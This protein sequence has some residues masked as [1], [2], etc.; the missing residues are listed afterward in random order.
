[1]NAFWAPFIVIVWEVNRGNGKVDAT[2]VTSESRCSGCI[3]TEVLTNFKQNFWIPTD[4]P[5]IKIKSNK[6]VGN[7]H[8]S[9]S[10][11]LE[12]DFRFWNSDAN[13]N[14]EWLLWQSR[15]LAISPFW[16]NSSFIVASCQWNKPKAWRKMKVY[17]AERNLDRTT[18][19]ARFIH[20]PERQ[21][22]WHS[23]R[24]SEMIY[25]LYRMLAAGSRVFS[26]VVQVYP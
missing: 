11:S 6:T 14:F 18:D 13:S 4:H 15:W 5:M 8:T 2:K 17:F 24:W 16:N 25:F 9:D 26:A 23:S 19:L 22:L 21:V 20:S 3:C 12:P 1:M 10:G 7:C